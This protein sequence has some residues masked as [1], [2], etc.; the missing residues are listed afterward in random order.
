[1]VSFG[2]PMA[3]PKKI[4]S[5]QNINLG[6]DLAANFNSDE[7][8]KLFDILAKYEEDGGSADDNVGR[9]IQRFIEKRFSTNDFEWKTEAGF[10]IRKMSAIAG[11]WIIY[12]KPIPARDTSNK[13]TS[14]YV[15]G[16][17]SKQDLEDIVSNAFMKIMVA[18]NYNITS[19]QA[20]KFSYVYQAVYS[21]TMDQLRSMKKFNY[22]LTP[23]PEIP[24]KKKTA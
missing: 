24:A 4:V 16:L 12:G 6:E 21:T 2:G 8:H 18:G 17:L 11:S 14:V 3:K 15:K 10:V 13:K 1:M 5:N 9:L 7:W 23:D 22:L 20:E 19:T